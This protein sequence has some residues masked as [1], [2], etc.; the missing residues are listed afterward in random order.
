MSEKEMLLVMTVCN[1]MGKPVNVAA[2]MSAYQS[3]KNVLRMFEEETGQ[4]KHPRN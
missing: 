4:S 1:L 2:V 3:S